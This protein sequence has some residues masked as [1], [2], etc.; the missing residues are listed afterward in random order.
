MIFRRIIQLLFLIASPL[1]LLAKPNNG[2]TSIDVKHMVI[3]LSFDWENKRAMGSTT[4]EFDI[5]GQTQY[6]TLAANQLEID[7]VYEVDGSQLSYTSEEGELKIDLGNQYRAQDRLE[8][9]IDYKTTQHNDTDPNNIWGSFGHGIRFLQPSTTEPKRQHQIWSTG[10]P[11]GNA[12]WFPLHAATDDLSTTDLLLT[13]K[14][15]FRAIANGEL[16]SVTDHEDG[17]RTYLWTTDLPYP[18]HLTSFVVGKYLDVTQEHESISIHNYCYP[19]EADATAATVVRLPDMIDYYGKIT[20]VP[21]PYQSYSQVFAQEFGGWMGNNT[22]STI[23]ENMVDDYVT[24]KDFRY[25]WDLTESE[26]LASQWYGNYVSPKSWREA[27]MTRALPRHLAGLYNE[28]KNGREEYLAY[29]LAPQQSTYIT[30]WNS[31]IHLPVVTDR[32]EELSTFVRGNHPY[33]HG[34]SVLHTLRHELGDSLWLIAIRH[35]TSAYGGS[36]AS[37]RDFQASVQQAT[38]R[39]LDWFFD[40]W[41]FRA[42]HPVFEVETSY[43]H[44]EKQLMLW[45]SQLQQWDTLDLPHKVNELF[46]GHMK[47]EIGEAIHEIE[48]RPEREMRFYFAAEQLPDFINFDFESAWVKEV[49]FDQSL[50]A[51]INQYLYS[52]DILARTQAMTQLGV[53]ASATDISKNDLKAIVEAFQEVI[54]SDQTY[55]RLKMTSLWQLQSLMLDA[56]GTLDLDSATEE[57]LLAVIKH[58]ESWVKSSAIWFLGM[59][60]DPQYA[61]LFIDAFDD[62]SDRVTNA[63][64][65]ALGKTGH[66]AAYDALL[67]LRHKPSWKNQSLISTLNGLQQLADPRSVDLALD[68]LM[69]SE[70]AHWTLATPIWDHRLAAANTLVALDKAGDGLELILPQ[71][72]AALVEE[73]LN[74]VFYNLLQVVTLGDSTGMEAFQ[75]AKEKFSDDVTI[76]EVIEQ[77]EGRLK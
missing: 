37:T 7:G 50:E 61:Q 1:S 36:A 35:F 42:G 39:D 45:V 13:V 64:A 56:N 8:I 25:L 65:I 66:D 54:S 70:A 28:Y 72:K 67:E 14:K 62:W 41:F 40:Q 27:W 22:F 2:E 59:S 30:D 74:D 18:T 26:A 55:W 58:E 75:L 31:G 6:I 4:L 3:E 24:H 71:L 51:W 69:N 29:Q 48:I 44:D 47:V 33:L 9:K 77:M 46:E 34:A 76:L 15:P 21:Y 63:A 5:L 49:R 32:Y 16:R 11:T 19:H 52:K 17:T 43:D 53:L 57:M 60:R 20:G 73:D 23:T 38:G 10:D 12:S 68:A